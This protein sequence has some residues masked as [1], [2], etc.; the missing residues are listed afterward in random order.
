MNNLNYRRRRF[1]EAVQNGLS[2]AQ[3]AREAGCAE[4]MANVVGRKLAKHPAI[5]AEL[6]SARER[7]EALVRL[8]PHEETALRLESIDTGA[9]GTVE[10]LIRAL[11]DKSVSQARLSMWSLQEFC[12]EAR[13]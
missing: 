2:Y 13:K 8:K 12:K 3:A 1:F 9:R 7:Q 11:A 10:R 4:S 5:A 6:Q